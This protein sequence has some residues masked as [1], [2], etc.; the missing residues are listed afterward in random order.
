MRALFDGWR[1]F[2]VL[3]AALLLVVGL[4]TGC[5]D[6]D[7]KVTDPGNGGGVDGHMSFT[8]DETQ[9]TS[10]ICLAHY[11]IGENRTSITSGDTEN[12]ALTIEFPGNSTGSF[13]EGDG[14]SAMLILPPVSMYGAEEIAVTVSAYGGIGGAI[15]GTFSGTL[16]HIEDE[17]D[18]KQIT[19]GT[20]TAA[21]GINID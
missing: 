21:R 11:F 15:T 6:D 20:F 16:V 12:W 2:L 10:T 1:K 18:V 5:S 4:G 17:E 13:D 19:N 8:F 7:D 3:P 14:T 9:Y